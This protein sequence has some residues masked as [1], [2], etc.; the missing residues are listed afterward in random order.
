MTESTSFITTCSEDEDGAII[1]DI[2]E[3]LLET[4]GWGE[5]TQ[6]DISTLANSIVLREVKPSDT[7]ENG[8]SD[9][10]KGPTS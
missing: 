2:P 4:L 1:L 3:E 10:G 8:C 6:L 9:E 5:G 7:P